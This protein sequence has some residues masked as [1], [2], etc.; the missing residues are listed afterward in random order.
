MKKAFFPYGRIPL[1]DTVQDAKQITLKT[2]QT[3]AEVNQDL[4][5]AVKDSLTKFQKFKIASEQKIVINAKS[6]ADF[7]TTMTNESK[8]MKAKDEK[9]IDA[10]EQ[11][12][13]EIKKELSKYKDDGKN[14]WQSFRH[15]FNHGMDEF[16]KSFREL[17][18][19]NT[20]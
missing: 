15:E 5:P 18:I 6:I 10:L 13:N 19:N 1:A 16:G 8:E 9:K 3:L 14:Q 12:N 11:K 7:R 20:E 2:E 17:G 4:N